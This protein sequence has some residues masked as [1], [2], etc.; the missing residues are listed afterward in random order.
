MRNSNFRICKMNSLCYS[1][2]TWRV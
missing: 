2:E 1:I